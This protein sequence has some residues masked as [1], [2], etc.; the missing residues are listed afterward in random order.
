MRT[1]IL[2]IGTIGL[3]G[4]VASG[5]MA[6]PMSATAAAPRT[7]SSS[8]TRTP[9]TWCWSD[10]DDDD[11]TNRLARDT[12]TNTNTQSRRH[13]KTGTTTPDRHRQRPGRQPQPRRV[14][15]FTRDGGDRKRDH[16]KNQT[17]DRSRNNTRADG[18]DHHRRL[19]P[20]ART[21]S[22]S[23]GEGDPITEE[24]TAMKLLGGGIGVRGLP[25]LRR[26]HLR[27]RRGQDP[28]ARPGGRRDERARPASRDRDAGRGQPSGGGPRAAARARGR[29]PVRRPRAHRRATAVVADPEVRAAPGAAVPARWRSTSRR[30]C[31]TSATSASCTSTSSRATSSWAPRP[32]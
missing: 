25:G 22:W 8:G 12:N 29:A 16:S 31:T 11:D 3:A 13:T 14:K 20:W 1:N 24:L 27:P 7:S 18:S 4:L 15:D 17:N 21:T 5:L 10:D 9:P 26:D 19:D 32:A 28:P 23:L 2:T 6:L 30:R